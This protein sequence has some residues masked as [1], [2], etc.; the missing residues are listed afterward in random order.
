MLGL[1][2]DP[3]VQIFSSLKVKMSPATQMSVYTRF[4]EVYLTGINTTG[5]FQRLLDFFAVFTIECKFQWCDPSFFGGL[6]YF[7]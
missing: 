7:R 4:I 6:M 2:C 5:G 1:T 3:S